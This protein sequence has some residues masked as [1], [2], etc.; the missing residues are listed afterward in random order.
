MLIFYFYDDIIKEM[1]KIYK[2]RN[3]KGTFS[4]PNDDI[5][6]FLSI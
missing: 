6:T 3:E 5:L 4:C 1:E 2:K